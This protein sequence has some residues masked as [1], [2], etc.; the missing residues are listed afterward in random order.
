MLFIYFSTIDIL[1]AIYLNIIE[2]YLYLNKLGSIA[3]YLAHKEIP[4]ICINLLILHFLYFWFFEKIF[5]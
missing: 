4:L 3:C 1:C 2:I 5:R